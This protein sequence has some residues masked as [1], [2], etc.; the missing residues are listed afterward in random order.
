M[1]YR[2]GERLFAV[3][4]DDIALEVGLFEN[5]EL[6]T[7]ADIII[8][9]IKVSDALTLETTPTSESESQITLTEWKDGSDQNA[10]TNFTDATTGGGS[11][12]AGYHLLS[13]VANHDD[14]SV[15][16]YAHGLVEFK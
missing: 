5:G 3:R 10:T 14:G 8:A 13:V 4:G 6:V 2:I 15:V 1:D 7:N 9:T 12:T 11:V 16:T